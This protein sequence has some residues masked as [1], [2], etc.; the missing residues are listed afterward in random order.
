MFR[1]T[2]NSEVQDYNP[3]WTIANGQLGISGSSRIVNLYTR[4]LILGL[5]STSPT[6]ASSTSSRLVEDL[7]LL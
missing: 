3:P 5:A 4:D 1:I 2:V 6:N 7:M